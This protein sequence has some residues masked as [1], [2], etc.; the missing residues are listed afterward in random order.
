ML[1]KTATLAVLCLSLVALS[2]AAADIKP[3]SIKISYGTA[4][5]HPFGIGVNK[6]VEL[7]AQKS[8][9]QMKAKGFANGT[10]GAEVPSI[11]S[12]QGGTI[13]MAVTSTSSVVGNVKDFGFI[14]FPYLFANER[15]ADLVL[16]GPFGKALLEKLPEKN[17]VGLCYW[18]SGFRNLTNGKRPIN[19]IDD[20]KG[21]KVRTIQNPVF[22]DT[23]NSFGANAV[24][25]PF[26]ELYSALEQ[27]AI[28]GQEGPYATIYTSKI[29]E[30]QKY[31]SATRHIYGA[32]VV[33][34]SK[35]FWDQLSGD[36]RKVL[37]DSCA[38]ARDF[39]RKVNREMTPKSLEQLK[40]KGM[41]F[42]E[43][44]Q[45]EMA[46]FRAA[47]KPVIDKHAKDVD[48]KLVKL[49]NESLQAARK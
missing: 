30:V 15:E 19:T 11:S 20:A 9:G 31:L 38:E 42:N 40:A 17:L 33:L 16:D 3:R 48:E 24:P 4:D 7:V 45:A 23:I 35:K 28:D 41:V 46:K 49:A 14:D 22:L 8:G 10:L 47:V 34:V 25:M 27:K 39:E 21:L 13:E 5:D 12:L 2:A 29:F 26:T 43:I 32:V 44:A 6:F 36:E 18:E 37:N 1:A